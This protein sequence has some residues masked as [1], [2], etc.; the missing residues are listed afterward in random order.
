MQK[1]LPSPPETPLCAT[2]HDGKTFLTDE[3]VLS[4]T[5]LLDSLTESQKK[6]SNNGPLLTSTPAVISLST[7]TAVTSHV[8]FHH[9]ESFHKPQIEEIDQQEV[10][11]QN[12]ETLE[13]SATKEDKVLICEIENEHKKDVEKLRREHSVE[14]EKG[15]VTC[16]N[17]I[18]SSYLPCSNLNLC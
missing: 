5:P 6:G 10:Q 17:N 2:N 7:S 14:L 13:I 12:E 18:C 16:K 8:H 11:R 9:D 1:S 15:I 3:S 4:V